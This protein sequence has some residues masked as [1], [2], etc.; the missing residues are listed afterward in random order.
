MKRKIK[1]NF[2]DFWMGFSP[3]DNYFYNLLKDEFDIEISNNPDYLF[4][5]VFGNQHLKYTN[6]KK[7]QYIGENISP[8]FNYADYAFSFDSTSDPRNY[9]LP[10]YLLYGDGYYNLVNKKV[11]KSLLNRKFCSFLVSN[12]ICDPRNNFF[13]K[14][15][16]S[17]FQ[18]KNGK[19]F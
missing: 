9:R 8:N 2:S 7:I 17:C 16:C 18:E 10:H 12:P 3:T 13:Q 6:C 14:L 11:D 4:F 15:S 5:S 1:I 19:I